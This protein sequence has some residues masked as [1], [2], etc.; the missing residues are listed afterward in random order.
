MASVECPKLNFSAIN[1]NSLN[2]STISSFHH[3]LKI[4]GI[5]KLRTDIILLS[6]IRLPDA[7]C[8]VN[9]KKVETSFLINP[10]CSYK[11]LYN[12]NG[13]SRGVGI[14]L[15][16]SLDFSVLEEVKD[17]LHNI[18]GLVLSIEGKKILVIAIYGPNS[19]CRKFFTDLE[20]ILIKY[21]NIPVILGGDWNA[22]LSALPIDLNPDIKNM[23]SLPNDTHSKLLANMCDVFSLSDPFRICHPNRQDFSYQPRDKSKLNRSRIDF[24]LTSSHWNRFTIDAGIHQ[25]LQSKLFD[26]KAI[27][28]NCRPSKVVSA[29]EM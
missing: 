12:S 16:Q 9:V 22:T 3:K 28:F 23:T 13:A 15:K 26:H 11:L 2:I 4:Y 21:R 24:F 10:Y 25:S 14:L 8:N 20:N 7:N 17:D 1:C 27:F 29:V 19:V 18:Y 5:V 6:D